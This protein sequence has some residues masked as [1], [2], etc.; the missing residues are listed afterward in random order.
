MAYSSSNTQ[1]QYLKKFEYYI[2]H[3]KNRYESMFFYMHSVLG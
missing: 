2:R 1:I 3:K